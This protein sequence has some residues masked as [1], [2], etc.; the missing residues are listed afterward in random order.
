M[1]CEKRIKEREELLSRLEDEKKKSKTI[2]KRKKLQE[3]CVKMMTRL[4]EDWGREKC[5]E[6]EETFKKLEA[7]EL[8][9]CAASELMTDVKDI[10]GQVVMNSSRMQEQA[11]KFKMKK[12]LEED[13]FNFK[14]NFNFKKETELTRP[15][16]PT[17]LAPEMTM[18]MTKPETTTTAPASNYQTESDGSITLTRSVK[19]IAEKI[20][21]EQHSTL[22]SALTLGKL[23]KNFIT[24][25]IQ[26][27]CSQSETRCV[28]KPA[29][30]RIELGQR[31]LGPGR[32]TKWKAD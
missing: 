20:E 11:T 6:E 26:V 8:Q 15:S 14:F 18:K 10:Q 5:Q 2:K 29:N 27:L 4:V 24:K 28:S 32:L 17:L 23:S 13:N 22:S 31:R 7:A 3:D 21:A 12:S 16:R 25:P 30:G 1:S 9:L 19:E